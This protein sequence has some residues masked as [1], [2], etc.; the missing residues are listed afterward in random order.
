MPP[1]PLVSV[2]MVTYNHEDY[3]A[4]AIESA[5][6]QKTN[7]D[8]EIII[9]EDF[10][11]DKTREIVSNYAS[12][13]PEKI[14]ALLHPYNLGGGGTINSLNTFKACRGKYI[15]QLE[16]DDYWIDPYKL[17]KQV[18]FLEANLDYAICYHRV[19]EE[20]DNGDRALDFYNS[21]TEEKTY[22]LNDLAQG[23]FIHT[24]SVVFRNNLFDKL[25]QWFTSASVG[26]FVVHVLNARCGKIKYLPD[27]MAVYRVHGGGAWTTSTNISK[28]KAYIF[29]LSNLLNE[30]FTDEIKEKFRT[31]LRGQITSVLSEYLK[32]DFN[33]YLINAKIYFDEDEVLRNEWLYDY[34]PKKIYELEAIKKSRSFL[35]AKKII[36]MLKKN[37]FKK[38]NGK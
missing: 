7:F 27:I 21:S 1:N 30:D 31:L 32:T 3:I 38:Q 23:N 35:L 12:K 28:K 19:Y 37:P 11:V 22:T 18:D 4:Q 16:G 24:P 10:S 36:A 29:V 9:G 2:H 14:T 13:Y 8:F 26:D 20:N 15:A 5:L 6:M 34:F 25:P 17:Q 33:E